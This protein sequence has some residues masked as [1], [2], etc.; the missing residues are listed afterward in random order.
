MSKTPKLKTWL[1]IED[2]AARL[3]L[4]TDEP[5]LP[6]DLVQFAIDGLIGL[7]LFISG[8]VHAVECEP[9]VEYVSIDCPVEK[10]VSLSGL[11]DFS[12]HGRTEFYSWLFALLTTGERPKGEPWIFLEQNSVVYQTMRLLQPNQFP[13]DSDEAVLLSA[14]ALPDDSFVV[15][16]VSE[17]NRLEAELGG[18][19]LDGRERVA[20]NNLVGALIDTMVNGKHKGEKLSAFIDQ[21]AVIDY[22]TNVYRNSDGKAPY[23]LSKR[24]LEEKFG[25]GNEAIKGQ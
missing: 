13:N 17:L 7:S 18:K 15:I 25:F 11:A 9:E 8:S 4:L 16:R 22:L 12:Q 6:R 20:Y 3:S 5:V 1:T 2:A 23:G 14:S 21:Q 24:S 19:P 10:S